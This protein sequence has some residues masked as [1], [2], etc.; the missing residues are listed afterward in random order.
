MCCRDYIWQ[1]GDGNSAPAVSKLQVSSMRYIVALL[2][3][4]IITNPVTSKTVKLYDKYYLLGEKTLDILDNAVS[5]LQKQYIRLCQPSLIGLRIA[6]GQFEVITNDRRFFNMTLYY[7]ALQMYHQI[8]RLLLADATSE[9][10]YWSKKNQKYHSSSNTLVSQPWKL[11]NLDR[12]FKLIPVQIRNERIYDHG[13]HHGNDYGMACLNELMG[14]RNA[15]PCTISAECWQSNI[16][17]DLQGHKLVRQIIY[18]MLAKDLKCHAQVTQRLLHHSKYHDVNDLLQA[19]C[20][21]AYLEV[22]TLY[23]QYDLKMIQAQQIFLEEIVFCA[24]S[25]FSDFYN[26]NFMKEVFQYQSFSGC[27][28]MSKS[29]RKIRNI[30]HNEKQDAYCPKLKGT[31]FF[32]SSVGFIYYH[33][34]EF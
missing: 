27:F 33:V 30:D 3:I 10:T 6:Q 20:S 26:Y 8:S 32:L 18:F 28:S 21:Y 2:I 14:Q 19:F 17:E 11:S 16:L 12:E 31:I 22:K 9:A 4:V 15:M 13:I 29:R 25:G 23:E 1:H 7:D 24:A 34:D 5:Y